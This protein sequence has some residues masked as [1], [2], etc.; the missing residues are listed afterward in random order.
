MVWGF[1][2][3]FPI[4]L[5]LAVIVAIGA[6]VHLP[7]RRFQERIELLV[8]KQKC[9]VEVSWVPVLV[10]MIHPVSDLACSFNVMAEEIESKVKQSH[11]R[12]SHPTWSLYVEPYTASN[13]P[14]EERGTKSSSS[15][16]WR[17]WWLYWRHQ[18]A[19]LRNYHAVEGT[20]WITLSFELVKVRAICWVLLDRF[21]TRNRITSPLNL[22]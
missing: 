3:A 17:H 5:L 16:V 2:K 22:R 6:S 12:P 20:W 19:D 21:I 4:R 11:I 10:W 1:W 14:I 8:E 9:L 13:G 15:I 7:V 18:R